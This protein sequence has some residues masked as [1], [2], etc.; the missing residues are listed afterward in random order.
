LTAG[1][2]RQAGG[3]MTLAGAGISNQQDRLGTFEIAAFGQGADAGGG[4]V[5]RLSEVE[6]FERL[7]PGQ[8]RLL[9]PQLDRA[10]FPVF[11][12]RL[13]QSFEIVQMGV[14]ELGGFFG[15]RCELR[16]DRWQSQ[17]LTVLSDTCDL[18]AHACTACNSRS[19][20]IMVG[21]GRSYA[22][23]APIS[24]GSPTVCCN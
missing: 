19:Y 14:L 15:E 5:R 22:D 16:T 3:K 17:R 11:H 9:H 24:I 21:R 12:L 10:S 20:S 1:S 4:D 8:V 13:E 18:E 7:D 23:R 2:D 6:L